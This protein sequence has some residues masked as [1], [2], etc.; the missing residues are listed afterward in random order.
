MH[1]KSKD[2]SELDQIITAGVGVPILL[3]QPAPWAF[4]N[5]RK[6]FQCIAETYIHKCL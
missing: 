2:K 1:V 6:W 4:E 5:K 3:F